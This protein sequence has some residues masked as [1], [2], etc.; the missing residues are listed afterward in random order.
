MREHGKCLESIKWQLTWFPAL[1]ISCRTWLWGSYQLSSLGD[2]MMSNRQH[3]ALLSLV[4]AFNFGTEN[5]RDCQFFFYG[6][7]SS[8]YLSGKLWVLGIFLSQKI[9]P[10]VPL[11]TSLSLFS[12]L[13]S[14]KF[15][16]VISFK[17]LD[18]WALCSMSC[19]ICPV[20]GSCL[21]SN[22]TQCM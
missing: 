21:P 9:A 13:N 10:I 4:V 19:N 5:C 14:R 1:G 8:W 20:L 17:A 15:E 7:L 3:A 6:T 11:Q 22:R 12:D 18:C 16:E 2:F